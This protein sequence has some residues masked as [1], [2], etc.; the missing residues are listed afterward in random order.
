MKD[1]SATTEDRRT[2]FTDAA[3]DF[4]HS[5]P[6][7]RSYVVASSPRCGS[8]YLCR[9]L[10]QTGLLGAPSEIF[11]PGSDLRAFRNRFKS[12]TPAEYVASLTSRRTS[13]SGVFGLKSH[14]ND[15]E[16]FVDQYP[17][18]LEVLSPVTYIYI[19][20]R[21]RVAQAVSM[22][23][24]LQTKQ[25]VSQQQG[26]EKAQLRYDRELIAKSMKAIDVLEAG[27]LRWFEANDIPPF[28]VTYEDLLADPEATVRSIVE[29]LEVQDAE[30]DE[31]EEVPFV[32]K[33]GDETNEE[34]IERF[35]RET[36]GDGRRSGG[37]GDGAARAEAETRRPEAPT[38]FFDR[39]PGLI[40]ALPTLRVAQDF[41]D[42]L[43][44]RHRYDAI[45]GQSIDL[46]R[47]ARVLDIASY[48]GFWSLAALDAGASKVV[49]VE[50]TR[51]RAES[52]RNNFAANKIEASRYRVVKSKV[53]EILDASKPGEFD[54]IL[55]KRYFEHCF[56]P[57]FFDELS[58]LQPKHVIIDTTIS[59]GE[60]PVCRFAVPGMGW[61]GAHS[62]KIISAPTLD[63]IKFLCGSE[64]GLRKIDWN[65]MNI[66]EWASIHDYANESSQTYVL[67]RH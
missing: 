59:L 56:L 17:A 5:T 1:N 47:G 49:A 19:S 29:L 52:A 35:R 66:F 33:Q 20:R 55:C 18:L 60:G 58:R 16:K 10:T 40:Q 30:R 7:R 37:N 42:V 36:E 48:S 65:S 26:T 11:N 6:L 15:F 45:I 61:K 53:S 14:F 64:F 24:A 39:N 8:T 34:W 12:S 44:L 31:M 51:K 43:R 4:A 28:H 9:L 23:R 67:E 25:W 54:V 22:V 46:F 50:T 57:E 63:L 2:L 62:R 32:E 3:L 21:D 41:L 27:W 38:H 13:R